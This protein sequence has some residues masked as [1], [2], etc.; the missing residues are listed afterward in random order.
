MSFGQDESIV[1][2]VLRI[3]CII[4]HRV[5]KEGG[6]DIRSRETRGWMS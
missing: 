4:T 6:D 3:G 5:K 2:G 1:V